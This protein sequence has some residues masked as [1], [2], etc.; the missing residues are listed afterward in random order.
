[1][2][3]TI[4]Y[5]F[6]VTNT[7][8]TTLTDI[9]ITD[10]LL[11]APNGSL[12]GGPIASLAPGA[13][14]T[15]TFSGSY[16]I[17]QSDIDA[18]TVTNQALATGTN[19]DGDDV[20]DT[21][22]DP[23]NPTDE[24]PDGDGDPDDPTDT[25]LPDDS[26]ISLLKEST[27]N[28][29]NGDG[30][31]QL[32]ETI[33]YSFT[34]TNTGATTLTDITITDPLLVAPNGSL[35]GGPIASLAPGAVDT[36]TFSG[37]YTIQ[38]SDIDAGT[39]TNQALATGTNP[40]GDDVTDTSDDPNNPTDEDPDGDGDPDDP[41]D[42]DLP[43]DS[44]ISLLKE[45]TFNDE[46]GD[47]FAQLGETISYSFTVTNTGAT[48][49][50]DITITDPLLVA[51]NG[52][53]TGGPIASLAPGAVDTTTFSGSYT[54]QQSDID[55]GTVSNQALATGTNPDGDDVTDTSDDPNNPTDEDPD[56]DGDP[57]DPTDTDLPDDSDISLL[58]ES[59]FN[60]ENGDGFAQ[61]G[62][63]ISY[64]FTVTNTGATTLTDITITDPLLVAPNGSL[65]GGPI[66]SLAPGAVDTT[67]FSGSYTIQQ[68]DID[69]GTVSNQALATG[70]NPDG[71]DVTDTSD[72]PN[73]PT[74]EDP[75][76]DGDPDDP[77]D[78][79]LPDDSD[80]SLLKESTFNDENGD[81]FA[82]LGETISY[83]FT[84]TNTGATTLTDITITDPL[85]VAPN[86]SL[87]GGPIA[88]LAPGAVD[89]T[90][91]SGSYTIQ[92][93]DIDAGTVTNQAL[94]TGT[95]P[96][97]DDVTD[98]SDDPNNPT[99]EDPD[100]DGDP[101]DPTDTDLPDDSDIS[102]LKESTFNDENGDGF[103]QLGETIS[104][105]FTV[106][107]TGATTLTDITITDPL[108]VA[109]NGS[110]TGGPIA[111]LAPGAVD[112]TTF[113]GSYT[114]QQSDID[115]GTV[116]NQALATGT[117]PDGDDVTDT[118]DDP[119]NPTDEDPDGD[120]DPDDPTDTD[121]PDD[122][123]ISLLKE[124]TFNDENGDGFAQLGET[125]SY[126]FTVTNTGA[127]TLTDITITDP[128]LD[129][130]NG[131]LTGGPIASLAPGAVDTTTFSGSYTIQQSDIDAGTVT[132]Q[133]LATGTN[134]DGDDVTDTSDD[135]NNP[136]DED[137]D[138][139]GDPDDPTDTDLPDDSD[140]SLLKESTFNDE[141]GD[142]FAQLGE[143]I[144]YS[145]T[146]TNTG[147]TTLTDIT[148]TDP[149]LDGANGTLTGGPIASLAPGAVD[150]TTFS[151]SYTIQQSDIDAGTVTNQALAT[152][153]N[154]DG[155]DVT[156]TS[157]DPNNPTDEDPDG[158]GD[159]DDPTDTD[160]PNNNGSF[161]ILKAADQ[162][163]F[164]QVGD[165]LTFSITVTN[166]GDQTLSNLVLTDDN[167]D[168]GTLIP[169]SFASIAPGE[170]VTAVASHTITE[171]DVRN[172]RAINSILGTATNPDGD[173][174]N[175][176]SDDPNNPADI[177]QNGDGDPDDPTIVYFD[178]DGDGIPDPIDL[179]DDDDGITDIVELDGQDPDIDNDND[180]VPSYLDDDDNDFFVGNEDGLV[181]PT[182]D[183][184]GD[185]V[186]NHLDLDV[187]NDGIYDVVENGNG[188]LDAD[189]DGMVDGPAGDNGIPD[190]AEDGGV[191]GA[192]V[193]GD[194]LESD[195]DA[196]DIPNYKDQDS[197][198]DG[199]TDNIE[200]QSS[201][202]YVPPSGVDS[203]GNGVDDAY[204]TLGTPIDPVNTEVDFNY[205]NQDALPDYLDLDS[206]GDNVPDAIEGTDFNADGIP[207]LS[208]SGTDADNDGL[209]D[210][211]DGSIGDLD[212][213]NGV[214]V[215]DDAF[216][217]PNRDGLNDN[218]DFRDQ[219]DDEDGLLTFE[220]G[221][222]NNDPNNG[223]DVNNDG[224]PTNDDTDGDGTPNYLDPID[225]TAL[226]DL[227]D[228]NDGIP[229]IVEV[230]SNPDIDN[231]DDGVPAYLDDDD[232]DPLVGN[233]DGVV[234][235]EFDTDGDGIPNHLDLDSDNDGV[236]DVNETG[237]SALDADN[238]GMVD[239]PEGENGI[240][241]A[242]EDGGIDGNGVSQAP[243]DTDLDAIPDYLDQDADNDGIT[244]N[245]ESQETFGYIAPTG[246]DVDRNGVDDAYDTNG[247][248]IEE[249]DFDG[250][251]S[252]DYIDTDSDNDNV[253]DRLEGHDFD[254]NGIADVLP[255]GA[256]VDIDGLDDNYDGD[257]NG[258][259]D[260]D[261]LEVDGDPSVLPDLDGTED[262]DY[263]DVD[264]DGDTVDTIYEDYDG[265][266]DPT[267][268]DTDSDG[269]PDYLDDNDDGDPFPTIDEGPDPDGDQNPNTGNTR[270][271]DGD[272]IF[273]YLEFDEE[274]VE[275]LCEE[276]EVYNGISPD[277]NNI[278]DFLV[279][280]QIECY[281]ENNLAIF[282]R[283][284]VEVYNTDNYGQDGNVFRGISEGRITIEQGEELPVGTYYYVFNYIDLDGN[285]QSK[286]GY[287]YIQR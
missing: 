245:V 156:D 227:D 237:N 192:G 14:D 118:S 286:A 44:D 203:D 77:T 188:D 160:L 226:F 256:D 171:A 9:T 236:Y 276:P 98:T 96:D 136:T 76:G 75:D 270:D 134:P 176:I 86:G 105:S 263:R 72:D 268:Q 18:G 266:N 174:V 19:P 104:Y 217:L 121:L 41:T 212:D 7:G 114:I 208:P 262:V 213:P 233:D 53:L 29:E 15:T 265:D 177:D 26:D 85:L 196:D 163:T 257:L 2:G 162:T 24:D 140:I 185:G 275:P 116:T 173:V 239:G 169:S 228:D 115:A 4:S 117:N 138:G 149:L 267:D 28:D 124:S 161:S 220:P 46:N 97:G 16:T 283:W 164:T 69:A 81:G 13:V 73:N 206:D 22:D 154:P 61:L 122:S 254:H 120:G 48:T 57:D 129:G 52:S 125:I 39:V 204:D 31:A 165:V 284:G 23:N 144:S 186:P 244:D 80:I 151:G 78:T 215:M 21:S 101:D 37:S 12:T 132:N 135:P 70:T 187:D 279:I 252:P 112:T 158:D 277:G 143:T 94:A 50:T 142:G 99:D 209:D 83:S 54:I 195:L 166:T 199:I 34:V 178:S 150:T 168:P 5:S 1:M 93:S 230:G 229:D 107:N 36:T 47:G 35:T 87:T 240:P 210:A 179:D 219:D 109:P 175:D 191:D 221:G 119:N 222:P 214:L 184:D 260:P 84:V 274:V 197:D 271:T 281:P 71:D 79:D 20:T 17:Q 234:N 224:D 55:A 123:D 251:G 58:K 56:G 103:A 282:N 30:F 250:D 148:I 157:D 155:D 110:L 264:D 102:L 190:A 285:G 211:F 242:A 180:G 25:D 153:T 11:V 202:G 272:G 152:G 139:D 128:L 146:V 253:P 10:P 131:T 3:E 181:N 218:P 182:T 42:T 287:I 126:S 201:S 247:S 258:F 243:R 249:F 207:D 205:T 74:D 51:P 64:S 216:D 273:D 33:S 108:L 238:D 193:S 59:T 100:G 147:A 225:D 66:A 95:N 130:A 269:I 65:T 137:P 167:A 43:D 67:T 189:N 8:A 90:T 133:A 45:S 261:G 231:D 49:L 141:N 172:K 200:S 223:E 232:N 159:P 91:F 255:L 62:E 170:S 248:P 278:N 111:S 27:F 6:T 145:F 92:Q 127:T 280:D 38:Q 89:T 88:S 259:G 235:P 241:D 60:D 106:T 82:Q 246:N 198:G 113:S 32:G 68:S 63:T 183:L 194:P 40:D